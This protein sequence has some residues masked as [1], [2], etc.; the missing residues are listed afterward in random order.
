MSVIAEAG[1]RL[2]MPRPPMVETAVAAMRVPMAEI[3]AREMMPKAVVI[4]AV[5]EIMRAEIMKMVTVKRVTECPAGRAMRTAS[6]DGI[7]LRE[8][9]AEQRRCGSGNEFLRNYWSQGANGHGGYYRLS[10]AQIRPP[11]AA[12]PAR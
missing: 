2:P 5:L 7:D 12:K 6:G 8:S 9:D 1:R 10:P 3:M 4:P 11:P